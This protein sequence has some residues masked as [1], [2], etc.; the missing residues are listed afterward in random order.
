MCAAL[1][2]KTA[3]VKALLHRGVD[4]NARDSE[5]H[6]ALMF[7]V[8]NLHQ[9]IAK[10]LLEQG[11]DVNA[12]ANNGTTALILAA[13][14]GDIAIVRVLLKKGADRN[15]KY[16]GTDRTAAVIAAEKGYFDIVDLLNSE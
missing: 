11:A 1:E 9:V 7:A 8:I 2:G 4:V 16:V 14:C 10:L 13:A 12:S 6:T 5:G 3:A 15:D